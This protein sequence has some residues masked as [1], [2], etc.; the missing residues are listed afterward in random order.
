MGAVSFGGLGVLIVGV[1]AQFITPGAVHHL[2]LIQD[3]ALPSIV[4]PPSG[5]RV[6][7]T[8]RSD[9]FDFQ[10]L[11][12]QT[13]LLFVAHPGPSAAKLAI[14]EEL[15]PPG[16]QFKTTVVVFNTRN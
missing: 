1:V 11:D 15:L 13:G 12:P 9:R 16:T 10:A 7:Q 2:E 3:V 4:V 6:P 5:Q 14:L 8:V